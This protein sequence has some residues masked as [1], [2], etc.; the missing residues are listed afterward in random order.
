MDMAMHT[1]ILATGDPTPF[2]YTNLK[3]NAHKY[4]IKRT[5]TPLAHAHH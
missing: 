1:Q 3:S 5:H 4:N 2:H